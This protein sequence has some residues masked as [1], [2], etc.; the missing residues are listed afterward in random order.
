MEKLIHLRYLDA[1][2]RIWSSAKDVQSA[3][4]LYNLQTLY[5]SDSKLKE[6]PRGIK[7][8]TQ[9]RYLV[10]SYNKLKEI[11]REIGYLIRLTHLDLTWNTDIVELPETICNLCDLEILNLNYCYGL[12]RLPEWIKGLVNLRHLYNIE[13]TV[14]HQI[15]QG[16]GK[17]TALR[18]LNRFHAGNDSSKLGYLKEL[19]QLSGSMVLNINLHDRADV[20]EAWKAKL[21]NKIHIKDLD[22]CFTHDDMGRT[23]EGELLRNEALEA[24]QPPRTLHSLSISNHNGTKFPNWMISSYLNHLRDLHITRCDILTLPCLGRLPELSVSYMTRLSFVGR[25]FLGLIGDNDTDIATRVLMISFPKLKVLRF[26]M[27]LWWT[28]WEDITAGE[29]SNASVSIM[30]CLRELDFTNCGLRELPHRLIRKAS[31][32]QHLSIHHSFHLLERYEEEGSAA[33]SLFSHI[34]RVTV[35]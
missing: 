5:L 19:D 6:I 28:E 21:M 22:I 26:E 23:Q 3:C 20:D 8:L 4:K 17:L 27:C 24:L 31:S 33:R 15:P 18:T 10:L 25:E 35:V 16:I 34:P 2:G 13:C 12:V 30:P 9:L 11:A 14:L 32:L 1:S 29:E 7:N